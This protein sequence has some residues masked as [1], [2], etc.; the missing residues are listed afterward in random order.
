MLCW[1]ITHAT[2]AQGVLGE[3]GRRTRGLVVLVQRRFRF[4]KNSFEMYTEAVSLFT[5]STCV[6]SDV[7][8]PLKRC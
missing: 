2:H 8:R 5:G 4:P 3:R 6:R 1:I 7:F